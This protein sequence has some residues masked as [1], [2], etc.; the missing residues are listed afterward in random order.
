M[1]D[2]AKDVLVET[3]WVA[4][5][6]DDPN[7]RIVEVDENPALYEEAHIPGAI[8][9]DWKQ[10]LQDPVRRE[11]LSPAH[12]S[13]QMTDASRPV[14]A[15]LR[16][17]KRSFSSN[18]QRGSTPIF[19]TPALASWFHNPARRS[20]AGVPLRDFDALPGRCFSTSFCMSAGTS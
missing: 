8:G 6:L 2:Y 7:I 14:G 1:A 3:D 15:C 9:V 20:S 18:V 12:G 5:H 17:L 13:I 10:D 16:W 11:F 19:P 4:E